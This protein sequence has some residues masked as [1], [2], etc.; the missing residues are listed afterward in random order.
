MKQKIITVTWSSLVTALF[1]FFSQPVFAECAHPHINSIQC[2]L[3]TGV[4]D[5]TICWQ[6]CESNYLEIYGSNE[7]NGKNFYSELNSN[8]NCAEME[9]KVDHKN[10]ATFVLLHDDST[11]NADQKTVYCPGNY[12][13]P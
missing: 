7:D 1:L 6:K 3:N 4:N 2:G 5:V 8:Q 9:L 11:G 10:T 12:A 13:F